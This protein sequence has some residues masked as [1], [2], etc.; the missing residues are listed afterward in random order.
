MTETVRILSIDG[1]GIRGIIPALVLTHLERVA[2]GFP[3]YRMFDLLAGTSTGA[4]LA[5]G[6]S[7]PDPLPAKAI[8]D[9]Y[10]A[11]GQAIF[12]RSRFSYI[13]STITGPKYDASAFEAIMRANFGTTKLSDCL[14]P[15]LIPCYDIERREAHFFKSWRAAGRLNAK[16]EA[17]AAVN[18]YLTDVCRAATA[19]PTYFSPGLIYSVSGERLAAIDGALYA[20]NPSMCAIAEARVLYPNA[21]KFILVSLGVGEFRKPIA[22]E[23]ARTWGALAWAPPVID[24]AMD[25][26]ADSVDYQIRECFKANVD[27]HRFQITLNGPDGASD[28]IDDA[29]PANVGKLIGRAQALIEAHAD[30]LGRLSRLLPQFSSPRLPHLTVVS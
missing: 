5:A 21:R 11:H 6:L 13:R 8:S 12:S 22:Y 18:F 16:G 30:D 26:T 23:T 4:I 17:A 19:A 9:L 7:R 24:C 28:C 10:L 1:G 3:I 27:Y 2:N 25:G 20:N 14:T 15:V 29:S